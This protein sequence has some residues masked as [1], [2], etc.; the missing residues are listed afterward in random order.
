[1]KILAIETSCDETAAAII[2]D[3]QL[4]SNAVASQLDLHKKFGGVLPELAS[5]EHLIKTIPVIKQALKEAKTNLQDID[6]LATT[7]GPGLIGS[8]LVGVE[9]AKT[10]SCVLKKPL[11]AI[12]HLEGH[13]YANFVDV[14][15]N[16]ARAEQ[17]PNSK[18]PASRIPQIRWP[19]IALIVSGGHTMLVL[20]KKHLQYKIL[21]ETLDDAAGEA[22]DKAAKLLNLGYPGGPAIEIAAGSRKQE[23]VDKEQEAVSGK[24]D[25]RT[26]NIPHPA[27]SSAPTPSILPQA[28]SIKLPRPML[29]SKDFDFSFSGL[30]TALLYQVR[31]IKNLKHSDKLE[32]AKEFQNAA[33]EVLV[34]KT[35]RAATTFGAKSVM[36]SGG[37]AANKLLRSKMQNECQKFKLPLS[38]PEIK[39]CTDNAAMIATAA[40]YR[41][42][43][44][45]V[46][47][48]DNWKKIQAEPSA[49]LA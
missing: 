14:N 31:A 40:Y 23:A 34:T 18:H 8:L 38:I 45:K 41:T 22:F 5:R 13:I 11:L 17:I 35:I 15:S 39:Y 6:L 3:G 36:L 44:G 46:P 21:G 26:S 28:S 33:V 27:S 16:P 19:A 30:K 42:K 25:V 20:M 7:Y 32:F 47:T 48:K 10:L 37:V 2:D 29:E 24:Q 4:K 1:M 49:K 9:T 12:N 43:Y